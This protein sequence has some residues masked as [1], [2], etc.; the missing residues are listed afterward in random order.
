MQRKNDRVTQWKNPG[1][2]EQ[3]EGK[4]RYGRLERLSAPVL[5]DL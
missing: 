3:G 5:S 1:L 4:G 2:E